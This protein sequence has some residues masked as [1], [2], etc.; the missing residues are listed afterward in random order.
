MGII[1]HIVSFKYNATSSDSEKHLVASSFLALQDS[2]LD[3]QTQ[4]PY[5]AVTGGRDNSPERLA[6]GFE[7]S[8]VVTFDSVDARD[9]YVSQDPAH[10]RF[11]RLAAQ[12][13]QE[14]FVFDFEAGVF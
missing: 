10:E 9:Y 4:R 1:T 7:H 6:K 8:F 11:K 2:C 12:H 5:L 3:P 13:V 14:A